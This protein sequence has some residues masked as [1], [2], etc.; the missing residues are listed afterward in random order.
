MS[1]KTDIWK[2]YARMENE[3][4][5]FTQKNEQ[6]FVC[7][8][9]DFKCCNKFN[10][11]RHLSTRKHSDSLNGNLAEIKK[12]SIVCKCGKEYK[13]M[14][15]LWKHKNNCINNIIYTNNIIKK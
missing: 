15:G 1:K 3:E 5:N 12:T 10:F 4:I 11:N 13:S 7:E 8:H 9:C 2:Y 6:I 14:S